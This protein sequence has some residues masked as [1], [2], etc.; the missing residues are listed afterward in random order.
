MIR[1]W[2]NKPHP[3]LMG[4]G[5]YGLT[6]EADTISSLIAIQ[7]GGKESYPFAIP[8][9]EHFGNNGFI[10]G[11]VL[12]VAVVGIAAGLAEA[13]QNRLERASGRRSNIRA[14]FI[15]PLLPSIPGLFA[16][17]HNLLL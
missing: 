16:T 1:E 6:R 9:V 17:V 2:L 13:G 11:D 14:G 4:T 8:L 7:H 10:I 15:V 12:S 5:I 3:V